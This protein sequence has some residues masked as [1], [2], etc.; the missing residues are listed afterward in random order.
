MEK[1]AIRV[2]IDAQRNTLSLL[3]FRGL[4]F[5]LSGSLQEVWWVLHAVFF[6]K[7]RVDS[8]HVGKPVHGIIFQRLLSAALLVLNQLLLQNG[9]ACK[10]QRLRVSSWR[11]ARLID[12]Q[13]FLELSGQDSASDKAIISCILA[14]SFN[15][16]ESS[17][18]KS[19]YLVP[20]TPS[21]IL[22]SMRDTN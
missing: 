22:R 15:R 8:K 6:L 13:S 14:L 10:L 12:L 4:G 20:K 17:A 18:K 5:K 16:R 1:V 11:S 2:E 9:V 21:A 3:L 19:A 7:L